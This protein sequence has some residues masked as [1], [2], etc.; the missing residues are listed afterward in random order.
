MFTKLM[1]IVVTQA[2]L[3]AVPAVGLAQSSKE[4]QPSQ[5][6][7]RGGGRIAVD[8]A[9]AKLVTK[10]LPLKYADPFAVQNSLTELFAGHEAMFM[11]L[12]DQRAILYRGEAD[13]LTEVVALLS[14]LDV[15]P[16]PSVNTEALMVLP[17]QHRDANEM[18]KQLSIVLSNELGVVSADQ[19]RSSILAKGDGEFIEKVKLILERLDTPVDMVTVEF[20][21]FQADMNASD[22]DA[23]IPDDLQPLATELGRFGQIKLLGRLMTNT[24]EGDSYQV[25]GDIHDHTEVDISGQIEHAN[26]GESVRMSVRARAEIRQRQDE[27]R[28][29][30]KGSFML[31]TKISSKPGAYTVL[32]TAPAGLAEG[33]SIIMAVHV[34]P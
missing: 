31:N 21:L 15:M 24:L 26:P 1:I 7:G 23:K 14:Q 30:L 2:A 27:N 22:D 9:P 19:P 29:S 12:S 17:V 16:P 32:G 18:A 10:V 33:Q 28:G 3:L 34:R 6:A 5:R 25:R 8:A 20:I 11:V 13:V 4:E